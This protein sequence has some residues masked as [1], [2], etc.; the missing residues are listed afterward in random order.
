MVTQ[1]PASQRF[2]AVAGGSPSLSQPRANLVFRLLL[3]FSFHHWAVFLPA[4]ASR[5]SVRVWGLEEGPQNAICSLCPLPPAPS[6]LGSSL[7]RHRRLCPGTPR[8]L[9][10]AVTVAVLGLA[11]LPASPQ[12]HGP[13]LPVVRGPKTGFTDFVPCPSCFRWE[14]ESVPDTP[15][16]PKLK[17]AHDLPGHF[18][19][20]SKVGFV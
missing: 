2:P 15:L 13:G 16:S 3:W 19:L 7:Q 12:D 10:P 8:S 18:C 6:C 5:H 4:R 20:P 11:S 1:D 9:W 14:G 17:L